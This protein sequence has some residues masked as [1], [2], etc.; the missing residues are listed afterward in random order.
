MRFR[1]PRGVPARLSGSAIR[2]APVAEEPEKRQGKHAGSDDRRND[3]ARNPLFRGHALQAFLDSRKSHVNVMHPGP[4]PRAAGADSADPDGIGPARGRDIPA[5]PVPIPLR[6]PHFRHGDFAARPSHPPALSITAVASDPPGGPT[7]ISP[8]APAPVR[9]CV[10]V[11]RT[12]PGTK[13]RTQGMQPA[14]SDSAGTPSAGSTAA[15]MFMRVQPMSRMR[16]ASGSSPGRR[17]SGRCSRHTS[18][19]GPCLRKPAG[20]GAGSPAGAR[21]PRGR[22]RPP[23]AAC[24]EQAGSLAPADRHAPATGRRRPGM[25][26]GNAAPSGKRTLAASAGGCLKMRRRL[27]PGTAAAS[28][29]RDRVRREGEQVQR[30]QRPDRGPPRGRGKRGCAVDRAE[31]CADRQDPGPRLQEVRRQPTPDAGLRP[32]S[33]AQ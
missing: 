4:E 10:P 8:P 5:G 1:R 22:S 6:S 32:R 15:K 12:L 28:A 30:R 11:A 27:G 2:D 18:I 33:Q 13:A 21:T 3:A 17:H 20:H 14:G 7:P 26:S 23:R 31:S 25:A 16:G 19:M 24:A 9:S 29:V